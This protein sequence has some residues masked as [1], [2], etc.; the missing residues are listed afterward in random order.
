[1]EQP[2]PRELE[3]R[4][5]LLM[6][7]YG[8]LFYA[9]ARTLQAQLPDPGHSETPAVVLRLRGRAQLGATSYA[10]LSDYA[11][12]LAEVGGRLYLSGLSVDIVRQI[13]RNRTVERA[14]EVRVFEATSVVGESSL[15]A[16]QDAQRWMTTQES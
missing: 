6:D 7:V 11:A 3:S 14:G 9:G 2:G 8:S 15:E 13:R 16:F 4:T 10:V 12:R 1:M 5:V